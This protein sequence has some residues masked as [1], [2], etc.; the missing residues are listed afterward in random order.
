MFPS[1]L[2]GFYALPDA[3]RNASQP[4]SV[5][6]CW[7]FAETR[8]PDS[9]LFQDNVYGDYTDPSPFVKGKIIAVLS[10]RGTAIM[11]FLSQDRLKVGLGRRDRLQVEILLQELDH[12]RLQESG[13]RRSD[14]HVTDPKVKKGK[15]N[16]DSLLLIPGKHE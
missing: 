12:R 13:K 4:V 8:R 16:A 6:L 10:I 15:K 9:S 1:R 11:K 2:P 7:C 14:T 3:P 5:S